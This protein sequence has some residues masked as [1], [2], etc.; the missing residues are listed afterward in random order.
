VHVAFSFARLCAIAVG[1][2]FSGISPLA[3]PTVS[4]II[5]PIALDDAYAMT[6]NK[7]KIMMKRILN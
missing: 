2:I 5:G 1:A 6:V 7:T 3:R 4:V